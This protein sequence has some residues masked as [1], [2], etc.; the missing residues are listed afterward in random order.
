MPVK[1]QVA[2]RGK[3]RCATA[4]VGYLPLEP[5]RTE[6]PQRAQSTQSP[7]AAIRNQNYHLLAP[8]LAITNSRLPNPIPTFTQVNRQL[9]L[10]VARSIVGHRVYK[11][12]RFQAIGATHIV[13]RIDW[14]EC[15]PC[16]CRSARRDPSQS[17]DVY[18]RLAW[19][20]TGITFLETSFVENFFRQFDHIDVV[21][22][23]AAHAC[24][25]SRATRIGRR[26]ESLSLRKNRRAAWTLMC[27]VW[28]KERPRIT[29]GRCYL[30]E[31]AV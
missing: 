16:V 5:G 29:D 22:V 21:V 12:R 11:P 28:R 19:D 4:R 2:V 6:R 17:C 23:T 13:V 31:K 1:A 8:E 15:L 18:A 27:L 25:S 3:W 30:A 20:V 7:P 24:G 9:H 14:T 26:G 10:H